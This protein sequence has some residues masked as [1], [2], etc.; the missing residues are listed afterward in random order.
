MREY[1]LNYNAGMESKLKNRQTLHFLVIH[2][3][4]KT[5]KPDGQYVTNV[6]RKNQNCKKKLMNGNSP[7]KCTSV[8]AIAKLVL[9]SSLS[10]H[11]CLL[12]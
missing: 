7:S 6:D 12:Y 11:R 3:F 1:I 8:F 4:G 2:L 9:L 10:M 5:R